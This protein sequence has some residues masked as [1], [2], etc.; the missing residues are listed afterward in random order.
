[1]YGKNGGC[2]H[3]QNFTNSPHKF[4]IKFNHFDA[5]KLCNKMCF[6]WKLCDEVKMFLFFFLC[7]SI[8]SI[9][10]FL[11]LFFIIII[12]ISSS[13]SYFYL[14]IHLMGFFV[15]PQQMTQNFCKDKA[16]NKNYSSFICFSQWEKM[17]TLKYRNVS[18]PP[19]WYKTESPCCFSPH[20]HSFFLLL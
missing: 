18:L 8:S 12:I 2:F 11:L 17:I 7:S 10:L 14:N 15:F 6:E 16:E 1:M 5:E 9:W 13:A 19:F 20:S 4:T 3:C